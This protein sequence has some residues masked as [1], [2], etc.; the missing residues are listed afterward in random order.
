MES[1]LDRTQAAAS[2]R[3]R[4][5]CQPRRCPTGLQ[6]QDGGD[7]GGAPGAAPE[8]FV[9]L[10][11]DMRCHSSAQK[12]AGAR[13][14]V[15]DTPVRENRVGAHKPLHRLLGRNRLM[16]R[17][18]PRAS[19]GRVASFG[20]AAVPPFAL[21]L[22]CGC[23]RGKSVQYSGKISCPLQATTP[24]PH[25]VAPPAAQPA[26]AAAGTGCKPAHQRA[27]YSPALDA[28]ATTRHAV[29]HDPPTQP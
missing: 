27:L 17:A 7:G 19:R 21:C 26:G 5:P 23:D 12:L 13:C 14:G 9:V 6:Q 25:P 24:T 15:P 22:G 4:P 2:S 29:V 8:A 20:G 10:L 1:G 18:A 16:L 3:T 28:W 11:P